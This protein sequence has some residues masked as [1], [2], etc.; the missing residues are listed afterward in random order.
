MPLGQ[1]K[2]GLRVQRHSATNDAGC[3]NSVVGRVVGKGGGK[4]FRMLM[5]IFSSGFL[6]LCLIKHI[7]FIRDFNVLGQ[8]GII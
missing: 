4:H 8:Y 7:R 6:H 1:E 5:I 2:C 3:K